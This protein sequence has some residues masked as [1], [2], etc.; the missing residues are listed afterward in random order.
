MER[1]R[2]SFYLCGM[3]TRVVV[4]EGERRGE[5]AILETH[6]NHTKEYKPRGT[7]PEKSG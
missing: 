7:D 6:K 4:D 2:R 3:T 5:W 1:T